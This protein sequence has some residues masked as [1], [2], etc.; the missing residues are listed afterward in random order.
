MAFS[1]EFFQMNGKNVTS[2][3]LLICSKIF[4]KPIFDS[5]YD[6]L[7]EN[8]LFHNNQSGF[9]PND[10]C[11]HQLID[12]TDN[13]FSAF[14]ANSLL[15]IRGVFLDLYIEFDRVWHD[16]L[17]YKLNSNGIDGN[18]FKLFKLFLINGLFSMVNLQSENHLQLV[19]QKVQQF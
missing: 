13:I 12:I 5:I 4:E 9:R 8:N 19:C 18:L 1:K 6:F 14:D 11:I 17:L 3:L 15:E 10:F 2:S 7:D 16:A